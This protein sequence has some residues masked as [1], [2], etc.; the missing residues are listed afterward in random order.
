MYKGVSYASL[1][2]EMDKCDLVCANCHRHR[3]QKQF[4]TKVL[5]GFAMK[6]VV[7]QPTLFEDEVA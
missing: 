3:T 2:A 1:N 4:R 6:I 7:K 5:T